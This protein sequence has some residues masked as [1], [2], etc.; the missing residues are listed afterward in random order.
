MASLND[1]LASGRV[2]L[3]DGAMGT[4]LFM[5]GLP[6]GGAPELWNLERPDAIHWVH[7][8]FLNAGS[9]I[10]LTN[11]FGANRCRLKL[12]EAEN[13][14]VEINRAAAGIARAEVESAGNGALV[15]GSIGP[16]GELPV[17]LGALGEADGIA[18]FGEQAKA[19]ADGGAD[20][21]WIETIS[22]P[23]ELAWAVAGAATAGLPIVATMTFDTAGRTMMGLSPADA[24]ALVRALPVPL[25]AF[26]AN[27]GVGPAQLVLTVVELAAAAGPALPIVAKGNA[28]IPSYQD[29][30]VHY[31]ADAEEMATYARLARD[32][33]ARIIGGCCGTR[34]LHIQAMASALESE[35]GPV[36]DRAAIEAALGPVVEPANE[37]AAKPRERRRRRAG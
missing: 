27:C 32:A 24:I 12:H 28:G 37:P 36:P 15:A 2:I 13:R 22:S 29:G 19:L 31:G 8:G 4:S 30:H 18:V 35:P 16:T 23:E 20:L 10:I 25:A 26:G 34:P 1:K 21:L 14:V 5:A 3:A 6:S 7:T 17:P 33:G 11:S 9:E